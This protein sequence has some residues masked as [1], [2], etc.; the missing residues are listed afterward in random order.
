MEI[1]TRHRDILLA[2]NEKQ[3]TDDDHNKDD[4]DKNAFHR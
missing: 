2:W 4:K 3:K 1:V